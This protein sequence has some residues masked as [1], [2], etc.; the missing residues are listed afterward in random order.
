MTRR[1]DAVAA[2]SLDHVEFDVPSLDDATRFYSAFGLDVGKVE[3]S[4]HVCAHGDPRPWLVIHQ[5]GATKKL[6]HLSF[7]IFEDDVPRFHDRAKQLGVATMSPVESSSLW[8]RDPH[9]VACELVV[10]PKRTLD[11]VHVHEVAQR[12]DRGAP[13]RAA[14]HPVKP[15]RLSHALLFSADL[16]ASVKFYQ[17]MVGLRPSDDAGDVAF[18]HAPLGSDPHVLAFARSPGSGL[19]HVAWAVD[20]L[21]DVALGA[22]QMAEAGFPN[23]WGLGRHALGSNYFQYVRDP[24]GSYSEYLC[25]IDHVPGDADWPTTTHSPENG[26]PPPPDF[27]T[28]YE[29]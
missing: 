4:L 3:T 26:P 27:T 15:R 12:L 23:G 8:F 13:L 21:E 9:G 7:G 28:N 24:W 6:R 25:D 2:H 1:P 17:D 22:M 14:T 16:E 10:A 20:S 18:M 11:A 29:L 5:G 19:H